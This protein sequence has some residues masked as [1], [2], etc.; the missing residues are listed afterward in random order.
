[1]SFSHCWHSLS[2]CTFVHSLSSVFSFFPLRLHSTSD[3][4]CVCLIIL[5]DRQHTHSLL[6]SVRQAAFF[7]ISSWLLADNSCAS[8]FLC[9][10]SFPC[11]LSHSLCR[12]RMRRLTG[13]QSVFSTLAN[14]DSSLD[15]RR[16]ALALLLPSTVFESAQTCPLDQHHE[17]TLCCVHCCSAHFTGWHLSGSLDQVWYA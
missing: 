2:W 4:L 11:P 16:S 6:V 3:N 8:I 7:I 9:S 17:H 15:R 5:I 1:M 14:L 12:L 13:H 10:L